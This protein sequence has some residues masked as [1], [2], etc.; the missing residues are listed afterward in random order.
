LPWVDL[1]VRTGHNWSDQLTGEPEFCHTSRVRCGLFKPIIKKSLAA[2][3]F[4][5]LRDR[6]VSGDVEVG[7]S[8]PSERVLSGHL[9]VNRAA[10][11]EGLK[12][13][14][15]AGLVAIQQGGATRVLDYRRTGGLDI[16]AA[17]LVTQ[18]QQIRT[19]IVRSVIEMRQSMAPEVA[20]LAARRAR[21]EHCEALKY[22]VE[23]M[24]SSQEELI[25]LQDLAMTFWGVL[26]EAGGNIAFQLSYH[27]LE[28]TYSIVQRQLVQVMGEE[29]R[30][31]DEYN[32]LAQAVSAR[33]EEAAAVA[34]SSIVRRG[35][36]SLEHVLSALDAAV[37]VQ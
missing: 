36:E 1:F 27:S 3:V 34:A 15:Q 14:E 9:G 10:V 30:A 35:S 18:D 6:I 13:L 8:L 19:G 7:E 16:L 29:L 5:Q 33:K 31:I 11:R 37:A 26:V 22:H 25:R 12:R 24:K 17:M 20:R 21:P 32:A 28:A 4:E 23:Q 2:G